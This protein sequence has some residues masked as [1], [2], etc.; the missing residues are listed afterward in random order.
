ASLGGNKCFST[1][2]DETSGFVMINPA[3]QKSSTSAALQNVCAYY[4]TQFGTGVKAIR[5]DRGGEF[6][7]TEVRLYCSRQGINIETSATNSP[8]Q[9]GRAER[10]NR[11]IVEMIRCLLQCACLP[12][13]FWAEAALFAV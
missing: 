10:M 4:C 1:F 11:V 7:S 6:L 5:M 13:E 8:H 2:I 12:A 9:N 3:R